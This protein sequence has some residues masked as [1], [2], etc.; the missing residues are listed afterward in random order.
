MSVYIHVYTYTNAQTNASKL[1]ESITDRL[2]SVE[3]GDWLLEADTGQGAG[4]GAGA[5]ALGSG[6]PQLLLAPIT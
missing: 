3:C 2:E 1:Q 5:W 4:A 6:L